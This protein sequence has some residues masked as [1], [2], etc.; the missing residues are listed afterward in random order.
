MAEPRIVTQGDL[1][2]RVVRSL[3]GD[4]VRDRRSALCQM[5]HDEL[6]AIYAARIAKR[7]Q[8]SDTA[9][10]DMIIW[11]EVGHRDG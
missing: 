4:L 10:I 9:L 8:L 11:L 7:T 3:H 6:L 1:P 5:T 2:L